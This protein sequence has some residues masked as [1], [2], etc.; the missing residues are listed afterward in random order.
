MT[1][2]QEIIETSKVLYG[3]TLY[4]QVYNPKRKTSMYLGWDTQKKETI[5]MDYIEDG[6]RK[7]IP[8]NDD[9]LTKGAVILPTDIIEYND[10]PSLQKD[11]NN[12]S[13]KYLDISDDHRQK[14]SWYTQL[15]WVTDNLNTIPYLRPLGD[16]G[17]GKTRYEDVIGGMC[18]KPMYV[19]GAVRSAP[20]YRVIDLWR[21]TAIF[22]EF[23]LG[24]SDETQDIIQI[25]NNGYQRGKPVLRCKD[26]EYSKVEAFDPFGAKILSCRKQFYDNALESRC[27]T[28]IMRDTDRI[29]IP[30]DLGQKFRDER[31]ELQNK[32]LLYRFR[33]WDKIN[34]DENQKINF[35]H[36]QSRIKQ[37][38]LPFTVLFQHDKKMLDM[39]IQNVREYNS[40]VID[41]SSTSMDGVIIGCY[42]AI[43]E[44][45]PEDNVTA[46][47]IRNDMVNNHGFKDTVTAVTI[48]KHLKPL[49]FKSVSKTRNGETKRVIE[50]DDK[51]LEHL[52]YRYVPLE[53]QED[54]I[55]VVLKK[56]SQKKLEEDA[57]AE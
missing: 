31:T 17:T 9:L 23:T 28:E 52:I 5:P 30:I 45:N 12:H 3:D 10:I 2:K 29:N 55:K 36:I 27:I 34:P 6:S 47:D 46:K 20:I 53:K 33:T 16:Y 48:G 54:M 21:G 50:V 24:K 44:Y 11:I 43:K 22:D 1:D 41:E 32:L 4:E 42:L 35:G 37:T 13:Y 25:L 19:G 26:G 8:I 40:L 39:F 15:T 56:D 49:G 18:Y 7:Y 51:R 38:F 14:S 57:D